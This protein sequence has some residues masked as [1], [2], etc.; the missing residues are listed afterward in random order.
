MLEIVRILSTLYGH[1][2]EGKSQRYMWMRWPN[3]W[4]IP[5]YNAG[6]I[7]KLLFAGSYGGWFGRG[8]DGCPD[9]T[10]VIF[11]MDVISMCSIVT[12]RSTCHFIAKVRKM[13]QVHFLRTCLTYLQYLISCT[14]LCS[15]VTR[16]FYLLSKIVMESVLKIGIYGSKCEYYFRKINRCWLIFVS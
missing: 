14:I 16:L 2:S 10:G 11:R 12:Y 1:K 4:R 9:C 8:S 5:G 7:E 6:I 15:V 13:F 3:C